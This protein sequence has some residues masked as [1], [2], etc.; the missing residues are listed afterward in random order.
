MGGTATAIQ[1]EQRPSLPLALVSNPTYMLEAITLF[2]VSMTFLG[3]VTAWTLYP[4][5]ATEV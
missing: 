2:S 4:V 1:S 5:P 3:V